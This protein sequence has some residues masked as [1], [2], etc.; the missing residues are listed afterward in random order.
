MALFESTAV[1]KLRQL[2]TAEVQLARSRGA[3][4]PSPPEYGTL[5][6]LEAAH[7]I[8]GGIAQGRAISGYQYGQFLA[9]DKKRF[10]IY[11]IPAP[12]LKP[13]SNPEFAP[14]ASLFHAVFPR[15]RVGTGTRSFAVDES[16]ILHYAVRSNADPVTQD[17]VAD[18]PPIE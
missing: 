4:S 17:E 14:G 6:D 13:S 9:P 18:W 16:G 5:E 1:G 3:A 2:S 12:G 10:F 7:L 8:E 11:A 15:T